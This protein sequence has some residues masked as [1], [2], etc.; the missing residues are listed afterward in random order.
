MGERRAIC[1]MFLNLVFDIR[2][3][4]RLSPLNIA[5]LSTLN[6][7]LLIWATLYTYSPSVQLGLGDGGT[8]LIEFTHDLRVISSLSANLKQACTRLSCGHRTGVRMAARDEKKSDDCVTTSACPC[9]TQ[10]GQL[11]D[12]RADVSIFIARK[13]HMT[14]SYHLHRSVTKKEGTCK[15]K[16][17]VRPVVLVRRSPLSQPVVSCERQLKAISTSREQEL[18]RMAHGHLQFLDLYVG[19]H[20]RHL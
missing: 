20:Y 2:P 7:S 9:S 18:S 1:Q 13:Y 17:S 4:A 10:C 6:N 3:I 16:N 15:E 8:R 19:T 14:D 5:K 11:H 12:P